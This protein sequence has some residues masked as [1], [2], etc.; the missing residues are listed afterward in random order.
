[1]YIVFTSK[2]FNCPRSSVVGLKELRYDWLLVLWSGVVGYCLFS[3]T[4]EGAMIGF[5]SIREVGA[6]DAKCVAVEE[7]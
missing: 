3:R 7:Y 4:T 1:M 2:M 6:D 5:V